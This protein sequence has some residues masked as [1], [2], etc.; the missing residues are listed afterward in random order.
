VVTV[1]AAQGR[2]VD[3]LLLDAGVGGPFVATSLEDELRMIALVACD[4]RRPGRP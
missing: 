3:A 4:A 2:P 1:I